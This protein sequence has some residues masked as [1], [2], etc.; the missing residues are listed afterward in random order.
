MMAE[1]DETFRDFTRESIDIWTISSEIANIFS[2]IP[3]PSLPNTTMK[4]C[5]KS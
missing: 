3:F 5:G 1:L 2:S 4:S